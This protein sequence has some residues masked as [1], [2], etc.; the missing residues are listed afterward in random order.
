MVCRGRWF[1]A[2]VLLA[3]CAQTSPVIPAP[4]VPP[5]PTLNTVL[6]DGATHLAADPDGSVYVLGYQGKVAVLA[7]LT[8]AGRLEW[9][10]QLYRE[11]GGD[12]NNRSQL[13]VVVTETNVYALLTQRKLSG[14]DGEGYFLHTLDKNGVAQPAAEVV[15]D[16]DG[17]GDFTAAPDGSLFIT[18]ADEAESQEVYERNY[19]SSLATDGTLRWTKEAPGPVVSGY[20]DARL[21]VAVSADGGVYVANKSFIQ[22]YDAAG[23]L[24]WSRDLEYDSYTQLG[25]ELVVNGAYI[26]LVRNLSLE[27]DVVAYNF[28]IK[29][30]SPDGDEIWTRTMVAPQAARLETNYS[31]EPFGVSATGRLYL[32]ASW[33]EDRTDLNSGNTV[34]VRKQFVLQFAA[35]GERSEWALL[36]ELS[37]PIGAMALVKLEN[38]EHER[39]TPSPKFLDHFYALGSL[40]GPSTPTCYDGFDVPCFSSDMTVNFYRGPD[41]DVATPGLSASLAWLRR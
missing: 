20:T 11:E 37:G 26:Y 8:K 7:K 14:N 41:S 39:V 24:L 17:V 22:K 15:P 23:T 38:P 13:G 31:A 18:W 12:P 21:K 35:D 6:P 30:F 29:R 10:T 1:F 5:A 16:A 19:L 3:A 36:D 28:E 33:G 4:S 25:A 2:L 40:G 9:L 32:L 27:Q 34:N